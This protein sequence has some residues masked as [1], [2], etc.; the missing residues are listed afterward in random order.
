MQHLLF[1]N[2]LKLAILPE[3]GKMDPLILTIEKV[4]FMIN[5]LLFTITF[6]LALILSPS[7]F[8]AFQSS[9]KPS[10]L[11]SHRP[12]GLNSTVATLAYNAHLK[13]KERG[14]T[15]S[16][17]LTIIDYSLPSNA[18]R[19]WVI[20]LAHNKVLQNTVVSHGAKT[21]E[22]YAKNFSDQP[23]TH[24]SSL[25]VF[26]TES[27]YNGHNGFSLR[28]K[29]LER[30]FNAN[31]YSRS[32]VMHGAWYVKEGLRRGIGRS[33][34]CPAIPANL[35]HSVINTIKGG[36]VV[37]AYYPDRYWLSH[38]QYLRA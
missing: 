9:S 32:I 10:I 16:N 27:T 12:T 8:G 11:T 3:S 19:L 18:R 21:G 38:S 4:K 17:I 25:G 31:A 37:F 29:G 35:A 28:L 34:G 2:E 22:L 23:G 15:H 26:V 24:K 6:S 14:L 20:D 13:A 36:S 5:K 1:F 33:W 7:S 30:G